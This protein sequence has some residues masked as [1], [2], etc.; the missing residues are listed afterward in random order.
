M[1]NENNI[2]IEQKESIK[3]IKNTKGMNWEIKLIGNPLLDKEV[4]KR[5]EELNKELE[6]KYN[7][8]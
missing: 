3:L 5:L 2:L 1:E 6:T 7:L 8:N 4:T